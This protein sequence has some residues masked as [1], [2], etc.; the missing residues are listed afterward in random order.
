MCFVDRFV[1]ILTYAALCFISLRAGLGGLGIIQNDMWEGLGT[2]NL[3]VLF[4]EFGLMLQV[5]LFVCLF[6]IRDSSQNSFGTHSSVA[7]EAG[8]R[9]SPR[10]LRHPSFI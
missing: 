5:F 7:R 4:M 8:D 6:C 3:S 2:K 10:F 1:Q 9:A